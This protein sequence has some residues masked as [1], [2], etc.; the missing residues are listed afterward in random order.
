[1][2]TWERERDLEKEEESR[3][4]RAT[5]VVII[6][7]LKAREGRDWHC[8]TLAPSSKRKRRKRRER[9]TYRTDIVQARCTR[10]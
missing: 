4:H 8:A 3:N 1:M 9:M 6:M 7:Y 2:G 5:S 10:H